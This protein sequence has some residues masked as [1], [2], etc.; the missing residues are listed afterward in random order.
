MIPGSHGS[1]F[2]GN[3]L[4]MAVGNAVLDVVLAPGFLDEVK[5]KGLLF[6][7]RL[8]SVADAYPGLVAEVR[9]EGLMLGLRCVVP[10]AEVA[11]AFRAERLLTVGAGENVLRLLPPLTATDAEIGEAVARVE[12]ALAALAEAA[13]RGAAAE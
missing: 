9:G 12:R 5:R 2:G 11:A 8:A 3:P 10:A 13:P 1:T 7:Q 6:K 4:A